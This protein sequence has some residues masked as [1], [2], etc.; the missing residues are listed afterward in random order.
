MTSATPLHVAPAAVAVLAQAVKIATQL[1]A[2][3]RAWAAATRTLQSHLVA[4]SNAIT[5]L[6]PDHA[7]PLTKLGM[8]VP[9]G[10]STRGPD[11]VQ[12]A[13]AAL[14][15]RNLEALVHNVVV[16]YQDDLVPALPPLAKLAADAERVAQRVPPP[17]QSSPNDDSAVGMALARSAAAQLAAAA[18]AL[19]DGAN[20]QEKLAFRLVHVDVL[21]AA[22]TVSLDMLQRVLHQWTPLTA[23]PD[24]DAEMELQEMVPV[25]REWATGRA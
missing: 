9:S 20:A 15:V 5:Q 17:Q 3:A 6:S 7:R 18:M 23:G 25:W 16:V 1:A 19:H 14:Q 22:R 24:V 10:G 12:A 2:A 8:P 11:A 4:L 13:L 21:E